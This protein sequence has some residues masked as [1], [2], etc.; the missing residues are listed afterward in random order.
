VNLARH[1]IN[2]KVI[3]AVNTKDVREKLNVMVND[4][5]STPEMLRFFS[6]PMTLPSS[7]YRSSAC[8]GQTGLIL[9]ASSLSFDCNGLANRVGRNSTERI[10][11]PV[12]KN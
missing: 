2:R 11:S 1:L 7:T 12:L 9:V 10:L 6:F 4:H 3:S 5:Y 8:A